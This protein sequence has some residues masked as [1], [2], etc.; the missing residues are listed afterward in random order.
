M[1][2]PG[3]QRKLAHTAFD[4][5]SASHNSSQNKAQQAHVSLHTEMLNFLIAREKN[6]LVKRKAMGL[7]TDLRLNSKS[8]LTDPGEKLFQFFSYTVAC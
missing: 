2:E 1:R 8:S 4:I 6:T 3:E 5:S 7:C